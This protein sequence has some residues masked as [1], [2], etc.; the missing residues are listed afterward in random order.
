MQHAF[1][2]AM[3]Y[4]RSIAV[5]RGEP[6]SHSCRSSEGQGGGT[7]LGV[8]HGAFAVAFIAEAENWVL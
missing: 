8:A 1:L 3:L 5:T 6:S 7:H 4:E 2:R